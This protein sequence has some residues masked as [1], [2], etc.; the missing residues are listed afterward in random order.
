LEIINVDLN[1]NNMTLLKGDLDSVIIIRQ[2]RT[3]VPE[4][5]ERLAEIGVGTELGII[6][7]LPLE[8]TI[9]ELTK[10]FDD[11]EDRVPD[12]IAQLEI[13]NNIKESSKPSF[14]YFVFIILSAIIAGAGLL[15]NS[16]AVVI[17][18]MIISP[19]MGPVLGLSYGIA[20]SDRMMIRNSTI[21]QIIGILVSICCGIFLGY[22]TIIFIGKPQITSEM[23]VRNFPNYLD[24]I[25][26]ICAG[27]AVGFSITG[28]VKSTLVGAA[29][30]FSL[31]PPAVNVALTLMFRDISISFGSLILLLTN[32]TII[33]GCTLIILKMKKVS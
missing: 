24:I 23:L 33:N 8:A 14:N 13:K 28:T 32:I 31:M 27:I 9:P 6:D 4:L 21:A 20:T 29:I 18:S 5:I 30:A 1:I 2:N 3:F 16:P 17:A 25:I 12:R 10:R 19:L 22:L 26:A 15:L 7:I 11:R